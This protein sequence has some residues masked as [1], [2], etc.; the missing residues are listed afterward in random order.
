MMFFMLADFPPE[1]SEYESGTETE[2]DESLLKSK[3]RKASTPSGKRRK[4]CEQVIDINFLQ[5]ERITRY[6]FYSN[7]DY[8]FANS[9]FIGT[10]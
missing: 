4:V 5:S 6:G 8:L 7:N 10:L 1:D 2:G 3:K 9:T